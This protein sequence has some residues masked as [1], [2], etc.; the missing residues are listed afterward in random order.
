VAGKPL[1]GWDSRGHTISSC[2]DALQRPTET[3]LREDDGPEMLIGRTVY[4]EGLSQAEERNL[5][6]KIHQVYDSAGVAT[7]ERFDFKGNLLAATRRLTVDYKNTLDWSATIELEADTY[8]SRT[9]FDALNRPIQ[10]IQPHV[11]R[12]PATSVDVVQPTYNEA[13]LLEKV[14]VWLRHA[15]E[16]DGLLDPRTVDLHAVTNLDYNAR[17]QR[18]RIDYGNGVQTRYHYDPLTFRLTRLRTQRDHEHLQDLAYTYDPT[19]NI[20][21]IHDAAQQTIF[22]RNHR[23]EP[24]SDYTYDAIYRLI[25]ATGREHLGQSGDGNLLQPAPPCS[26]DAPRVGL[27][28]PGDGSAMGRYVEQF[29]YDAVGNFKEMRHRGTAPGHPGWTRSYHYDE[30]SQLEP[31]KTNNRLSRTTVGS[32]T[33]L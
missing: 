9:A 8:H 31:G 3:Y 17:G 10:L 18:T 19:G 12:G 23:V 26:T 5:R 20:T 1:R 33:E 14:D 21:H 30:S 15:S 29:V 11:Q 7:N 6:G 32:V 2:Y 27:L 16:P 28:H 25:E 13:N 22:F 4:G 24:S